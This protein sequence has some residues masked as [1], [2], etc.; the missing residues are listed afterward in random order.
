MHKYNVGANLN[1]VLKDLYG[2][3][4]SAVLFNGRTGDWFPTSVGV[5]QGCLLSP[6]LFNVF[7][8]KI[9]IDVLENQDGTVSTGGRKF[10]N[11]RFAHDRDGLASK[12][13]I[14]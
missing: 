9:L 1:T 3:A 2:K 13:E 7:L 4:T 8:E 14:T 12:E 10:T 5:R 6:T 11:L